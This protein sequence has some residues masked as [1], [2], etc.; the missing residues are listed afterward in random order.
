MCQI[1]GGAF[2]TGRLTCSLRNRCCCMAEGADAQGGSGEQAG[3]VRTWPRSTCLRAH[4]PVHEEMCLPR[5]E[6]SDLPRGLTHPSGPQSPSLSVLPFCFVLF[7]RCWFQRPCSQPG[8][9][10]PA[11][12]ARAQP[13]QG[14][15]E[16]FPGESSVHRGLGRAFWAK[17]YR[18]NSILLG[19][20][21]SSLPVFRSS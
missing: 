21:P 6:A 3:G 19:S 1:L 11:G 5:G 9:T 16:S 12:F 10:G 18:L 7:I 17:V 8:C 14:G 4:T 13:G 15:L 20:K 2:C